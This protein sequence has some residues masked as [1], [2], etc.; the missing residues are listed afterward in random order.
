MAEI[1]CGIPSCD[2][3]GIGA[4]G[5]VCLAHG[6]HELVGR[7]DGGVARHVVGTAGGGQAGL[8]AGLA[9]VHHELHLVGC[10]AEGSQRLQVCVSVPM[11]P[12]WP[13]SCQVLKWVMRAVRVQFERH[14]GRVEHADREDETAQA[15]SDADVP[16][17]LLC[18][19]G[20]GFVLV[21]YG[22]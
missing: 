14:F 19:F 1:F 11:S 7:V 8:R 4:I 17:L 3:F 6:I 22:L 21:V 16:A 2:H 13:M 5:A 15:Q 9:V 10:D 12:P 20:L 18:R